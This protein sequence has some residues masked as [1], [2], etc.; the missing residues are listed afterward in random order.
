MGPAGESTGMPGDGALPAAAKT[1]NLAPPVSWGELRCW[2][3]TGKAGG[4]EK[5]GFVTKIMLYSQAGVVWEN[6][7]T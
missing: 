7:V 2:A 6:V 4:P 5:F 3:W 1:S